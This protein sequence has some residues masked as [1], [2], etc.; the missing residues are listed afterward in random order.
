MTL[1]TDNPP[2]Y[3]ESDSAWADLWQQGYAHTSADPAVHAAH[4]IEMAARVLRDPDQFDAK[5]IT[6]ARAVFCS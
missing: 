1:P 3:P 5:Q 4:Q 6:W 2:P